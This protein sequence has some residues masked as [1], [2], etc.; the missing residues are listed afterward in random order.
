MF[1]QAVSGGAACN[2]YILKA[3][4]LICHEYGYTVC[5]PPPKY[6]TDNGAMIAWNGLERYL[7][8]AGIYEHDKID[9]IRVEPK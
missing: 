4:E 9:D 5:V 6:C 7:N 8:N 1:R 3:F 2:K